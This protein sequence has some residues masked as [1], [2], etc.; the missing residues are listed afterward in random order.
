MSK[1]AMKTILACTI[2][3]AVGVA[4][5]ASAEQTNPN[6]LWPLQRQQLL[7]GTYTGKLSSYTQDCQTVSAEL[8]LSMP[9]PSREMQRYTLK[10]ICIAGGQLNDPPR[11]I[12]GSW[13]LNE[14]SGSCLTL[15][16]MDVNDPMVG[17]NIYG[18]AV[19]EDQLTSD[20]KHPNY[21]LAQDGSNCHS[22]RSPEYDDKVLRRVR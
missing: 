9:M 22:G 14:S 11:T 18:F 1:D 7:T 2:A 15:N 21:L 16:F 17:P 6:D 3:I 19:E 20:H 4:S 13:D 12:T 8:F 10:T 5:T